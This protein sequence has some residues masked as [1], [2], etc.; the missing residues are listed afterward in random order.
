MDGFPTSAESP[1]ALKVGRQNQP[2]L[3]IATST[4][5]GNV[6]SAQ[7]AV[8]KSTISAD[9]IVALVIG[10]PSLLV[11]TISLWVPYLTY[12]HTRRS[13]RTAPWLAP[14]PTWV[15]NT[16]Y[17]LLCPPSALRSRQGT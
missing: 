8:P 3:S 16:S 11:A 2:F 1:A 5:A 12:K 17:E 15:P 14:E 4:L 13:E 10:I 9:T 6:S 7:R